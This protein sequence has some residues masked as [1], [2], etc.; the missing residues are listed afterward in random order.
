MRDLL[1]S[2]TKKDFRV[3]FYRASGRGGQHR[4]K[5]ESACRIT[6]LSTGISAISADQR[7]QHQNRKIAFRRLVQK[8]TP[9]FQEKYQK[10]SNARSDAGFGAKWLRTYDERSNIVLDKRISKKFCFDDVIDGRGLGVLLDEIRNN[11]GES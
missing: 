1:E 6:H 5:T 7:S 2:L 8:L 11:S 10:D 4:N 3:E 9:I